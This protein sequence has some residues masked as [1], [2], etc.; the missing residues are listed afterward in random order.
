MS[1][2]ESYKRVMSA[3]P[4]FVD[5]TPEGNQ[6]SPQAAASTHGTRAGATGHELL[7]KELGAGK[8][9]IR[10]GERLS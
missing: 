4:G 3:T 2:D 9:L 1:S 5:F 6:R 10:P 8:R 7:E